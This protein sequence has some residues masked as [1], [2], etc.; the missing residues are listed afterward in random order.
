[1]AANRGFNLQTK[2]CIGQRTVWVTLA[3]TNVVGKS[4]EAFASV[5]FIDD[6]AIAVFVAAAVGDGGE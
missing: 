6:E 3:Y 4:D 1:M 5:N 2:N